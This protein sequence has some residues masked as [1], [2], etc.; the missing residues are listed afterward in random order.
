[1]KGAIQLDKKKFTSWGVSFGSL[2]LV[3]GMVSYLGLTTA[4]KTANA[5][6]TTQTPAASQDSTQQSQSFDGNNQDS[7]QQSQ[8]SGGDNQSSFDNSNSS[9]DNGSNSAFGSDDQTS[10]NSGFDNGSSQDNGQFNGGFSGQHRSFDTT[11][12]AS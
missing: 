7:F 12:G 11:T 5:N 4:N 9:D 3:A 10:D 1:V 8:S 6:I 2:A